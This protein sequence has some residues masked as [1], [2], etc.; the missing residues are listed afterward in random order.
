MILNF[1]LHSFA[2]VKVTLCPHLQLQLVLIPVCPVWGVMASQ[3]CGLCFCRSLLRFSSLL[4]SC[5]VSPETFPVIPEGW[6]RLGLSQGLGL[7]R[8]G[9][10]FPQEGSCG[11]GKSDKGRAPLPAS[12]QRLSFT[13]S[14]V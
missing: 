8:G 6:M 3:E 4:S 5:C 1:K 13:F 2:M 10:L 11:L 14:F 12:P 7:H 9:F